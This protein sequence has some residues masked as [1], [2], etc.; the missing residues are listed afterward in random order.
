MLVG[1]L[2]VGFASKRWAPRTSLGWLMLAPIFVDLWWGLFILLGVEKARITPGITRAI[3][4]QLDYM[5]YTHSLIGTAF[6]AALLAGIYFALHKN[7]RV[8]AILFAGVA[9]HWLLDFVSH[10]A[11]HAALA[12]PGPTSGWAC[13]ITRRPR[14]WWR[15]ACWPAGVGLY[16]SA[17]RPR[18]GRVGL[19][20]MVTILFALNLATSPGA[21]AE[22][23]SRA[24]RRQPVAAVGGVGHGAH[25]RPPRPDPTHS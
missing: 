17:T 9:S 21:G 14:C 23:H 13:G 6:W 10:R 12:W 11:G 8:A 16:L 25:R 2:A 24:R 20:V 3:P 1:H 7:T 22:R 4:L 18:G 5:P 15:R 19:A